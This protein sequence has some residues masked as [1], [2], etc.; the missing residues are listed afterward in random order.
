MMIK[1]TILSISLLTVMSGAAVAPAVA[2][3]LAAFP[4]SSDTLGKLVLT[5]PALA[6]MPMSLMTGYLSRVISRKTMLYIGLVLYITGGAGG[7]MADSIS[8]L[9]TMRFILGLGVG[10]LMPLSAGIIAEEYTGEEK[11]RTMGYSG[12]ASNLGGIIAT[13]LSGVLALYHWRASFSIYLLGFIVLVLAFVFI[14]EKKPVK[15]AGSGGISPKDYFVYVL[16]GFAMFFVFTA[17]YA[18]PVNIS[19][20]ITQNELGR[21][22]AAGVAMSCMTASSFVMGIFFGRVNKLLRIWL[23]FAGVLCF[24]TGFYLLAFQG[25]LASTFTAMSMCGLSIGCMVPYIMNG[26]TSYGSADSKT[27]GTSIAAFF[28][29]AGQFSSPVI[30]EYAAS[31]TFGSGINNTFETLFTASA[32]TAAGMFAINIARQF[33]FKKGVTI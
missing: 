23:P 30:T 24:T 11:V 6:I 8:S 27:V 10:F 15:G 22:A 17:F 16:W 13:T 4:D 33:L 20:Y 14:P 32:I 29:F 19:L 9:L 12:A 2:D 28:I 21:S 18:V 25:T 3:I 26:V 1:L 31:L 7:G 5:T